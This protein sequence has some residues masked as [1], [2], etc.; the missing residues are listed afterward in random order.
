MRPNSL[1]KI[2]PIPFTTDDESKLREKLSKFCEKKRLYC[3][4]TRTIG[5]PYRAVYINGPDAKLLLI[6]P[7]V[8][9]YGDD[10][11]RSEELS[12]FDKKGRKARTVLRAKY[13][14][15]ECDNLGTVIFSGDETEKQAD[16]NE[17]IMV[18]QMIDLLDGFTIADRNINAP[19]NNTAK[20]NAN[21]LVLAKNQEGVIEHIK[22]KN[23]QRY[24]DKGYVIL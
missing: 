19:I 18:Q 17:C 21:D 15:V 11:V 6:N 23:V 7:I 5:A 1:R 16:L 4:S 3:V 12:E 2:E 13:I 9:K 20:Y 10:K 8:T 14:E 24:I 22:Y